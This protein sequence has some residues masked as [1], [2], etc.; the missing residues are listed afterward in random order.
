MSQTTTPPPAETAQTAPEAHPTDAAVLSSATVPENDTPTVQSD[1]CA[2]I[3]LSDAG[4]AEAPTLS[5]SAAASVPSAAEG[6]DFSGGNG[7]APIH[8]VSDDTA[9]TPANT[10]EA[11]SPLSAASGLSGRFQ[12]TASGTESE[13]DSAAPSP[14]LP[15]KAENT[16]RAMS[17]AAPLFLGILLLL[18]AF[19]GLYFPAVYLPQEVQYLNALQLSQQQGLWLTPLPTDQALLMPAY[20]W[21]LNIVSLLVQ[22]AESVLPFLKQLPAGDITLPLATWG[23]ALL[24]LLGTC[25]LGKALGMGRQGA[26]AAG[27]VLL[28]SL[29]FVPLAHVAGPALLLAG[30]LTFALSFLYRGWKKESALVQLC[31]GFL[32]T[33]LAFLLGGIPALLLPLLT[34]LIYLA[35]RRMLRRGQRMDA[36]AGF[37]AMLV[38]LLAWLGSVIMFTRDNGYIAALFRTQIVPF[39]KPPFWPSSESSCLPVA[40][41]LVALLPWLLILPFISWFRVGRDCW[42][43]LRNTSTD[44]SGAWL[45]IA[46]VLG[47]ILNTMAAAKTD[48]LSLLLCWE[49]ILPL[50]P[51]GALLT[52]RALLRLTPAASRCFYLLLAILFFLL[53]LGFALLGIPGVP[54]QLQTLLPSK[55]H[56]CLPLLASVQG[57]PISGAVLLLGAVALWRFTERRFPGG[58]LVI[59]VLLVTVLTQPFCLMHMPSIYK[60]MKDTLPLQ[61]G[62]SRTGLPASLTTPTNTAPAAT[63]ET[64][65]VPAAQPA[66]ALPDQPAA[67]PKPSN[68]A[69]PDQPA[70]P[71]A[72]AETAPDAPATD[73]ATPAPATPETTAPVTPE[74]TPPVASPTTQDETSAAPQTPPEHSAPAAENSAESS[75]PAPASEQTAPATPDATGKGATDSD[76]GAENSGN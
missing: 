45:W 18:Q 62:L 30:V 33:G 10:S 61:R 19:A 35:G 13:N 72:Q 44:P 17:Y 40:A 28:S 68:T 29:G 53:G 15:G 54:A 70:L 48:T 57:L 34:S 41:L 51:L 12:K 76:S 65:K 66:S 67:T 1:N 37:I 2:D 63:P 49:Y 58:A 39:L 75:A 42:K 22:L 36:I 8:T 4:H 71:P 7:T 31:T 16:F 27:L 46:L 26:F 32:L 60:T 59:V 24:A 23:S 6:I 47:L 3:P 73:A 52:A 14:L 11:A 20:F 38:L 43:R 5:P 50:L 21:F 64:P 55:L 74:T 56:S 69:A 25:S 9:T